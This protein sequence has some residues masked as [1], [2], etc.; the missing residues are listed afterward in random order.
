[1]G[2]VYGLLSALLFGANGSVAKLVLQGGVTAGQLTFFR[3]LGAAILA[4]AV[5]L[6]T[7]RASLRLRPRMLLGSALL[8]LV[9]VALVQWLY[10][11]AIDRLPVGIALLLEYLAVP[12]VALVAWLLL[13]ERVRPQLWIAIVLVVGGLAIVARVGAAPL[14]AVGVVAALAAAAALAVYFLLGERGVASAPPL[15]IAFWSMLFAAA[16]WA[17]PSGWWQVSPATLGSPL[18]LT[19]G[20]TAPLWLGLLWVIAMG[21]FAPYALSY[22][23]IR[24]LGATRAGIL[25]AA[26]V[27]FA[28]AVAWVWLGEALS[29][30]QTAGAVV[31]LA[32]IVV[33]QTARP[34]PVEADL[35]IVPGGAVG[36]RP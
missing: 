19:E 1:V 26:E 2:Y 24:R 21:S 6:A 13:K 10:A 34:T 22:L 15:V 12:L 25:A 17:I 29:V 30:P 20:A 23:A 16:F 7:D 36:G 28:F 4:G 31:V 18:A 27:V 8:G 35:A 32:G 9:G 5:V 11:V 14:D 33:A 3:C